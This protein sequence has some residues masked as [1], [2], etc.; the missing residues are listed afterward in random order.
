M[1]LYHDSREIGGRNQ[2]SL[3]RGFR[4]PSTK[5]DEQ[6]RAYPLQILIWHEIVNDTVNDLPVVVTFCPLCNTALVF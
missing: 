6:V 1:E 3:Q 4:F 5:Q 2:P